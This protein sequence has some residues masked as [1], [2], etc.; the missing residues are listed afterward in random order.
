MKRGF[1]L[2]ETIIYTAIV[3]VVSV[4]IFGAIL[5]LMRSFY[6]I[7]IVRSLNEGARSGIERI[8]REIRAASNIDPASVFGVSPGYLKLNTTDSTGNPATMEFLVEDGILKIKNN[9][10]SAEAITMPN[11]N[12][13]NLVFHQI[14][15]SS[16]TAGIKTELELR[17]TLNNNIQKVEKFYDTALI[18][19]GNL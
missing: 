6:D 11:V 13:S 18:R 1:T 9:G 8:V 10:G 14:V 5:T 4:V 19:S 15:A 2:I 17:A 16:T 7:R 12:V 3:A